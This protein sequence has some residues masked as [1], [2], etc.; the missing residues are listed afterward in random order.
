MQSIFS[1]AA[2]GHDAHEIA[3]ELE[4]QAIRTRRGTRW[5]AHRVRQVLRQRHYVGEWFT[6]PGIPAKN[7]PPSLI[8][9]RTFAKA[10][11]SAK[12][13]WHRRPRPTRPFILAGLVECGYCG[14]RHDNA[15]PPGTLSLLRVQLGDARGRGPVCPSKHVCAERVE[16]PVL[17]FRQAPR[18]RT[19]TGRR[20][21][22][23][24]DGAASAGVGSGTEASRASTDRRGRRGSTGS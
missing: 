21:P 22:K 6:A 2:S 12:H 20:M 3:D 9:A 8:D 23:A 16:E 24:D 13:R 1:L 17:G 4:R 18:R 7:P 11:R 10:Q 15:S 19:G 14:P 5:Q